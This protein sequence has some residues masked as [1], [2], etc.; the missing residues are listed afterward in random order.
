MQIKVKVVQNYGRW[1]YYPLCKK[2]K[3]FAKIADTQTLTVPVLMHIKSLGYELDMV[4]PR[5]TMDK[6]EVHASVEQ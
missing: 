5:P 6:P 1:V 2:A 4:M 3:L